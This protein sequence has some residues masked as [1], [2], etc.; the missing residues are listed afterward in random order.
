[1]HPKTIAAEAADER[2]PL[3][4]LNPPHPILVNYDAADCA[5]ADISVSMSFD[6]KLSLLPTEKYY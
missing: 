6:I 5:V 1:M 3:M 4:P 2:S